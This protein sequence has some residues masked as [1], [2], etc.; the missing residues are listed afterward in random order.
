MHD[1]ELLGSLFIRP[2]CTINP[3]IINR[4]RT[5]EFIQAVF[6]NI[7]E[8]LESHRK[9]LDDLHA[10]Q[11]EEHPFIR[12]ISIPML[13]AALNWRDAYMEYITHYPIALYN[14]EEEI[15]NNPAFKKFVEDAKNHPDARK[16]DI[17]SFINRPIPR[18]LK[19]ELILKNMLNDTPPGSTD[20]ADLGQICDILRDLGIS[21]QHGAA[22][23]ER[24]VFLWRY[25][26]DLVFQP[27]DH[28]VR[29]KRIFCICKVDDV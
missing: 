1:L 14:L 7:N 23:S 12:S 8:L 20:H 19:Y 9:L 18:L 16:L 21:S 3:P 5:S 10:L 24:K 27:G 26:A 28:V 2:L 17:R 22:A 4:D 25:T 15:V 6:Y 11:R 29:P 13:D